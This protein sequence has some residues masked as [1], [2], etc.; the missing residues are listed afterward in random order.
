MNNRKLIT[1]V[2]MIVLMT[3]LTGIVLTATMPVW[4]TVILALPNS[5]RTDLIDKMQYR[6]AREGM[7][8]M[9][10]THMIGKQLA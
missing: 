5:K 3:T 7:K 4:L 9:F 10:R 6:I 2:A 1:A 8:Y